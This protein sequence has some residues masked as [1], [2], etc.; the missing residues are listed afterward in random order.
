M[1]RRFSVREYHKMIEAGVF[2][3]GEPIELLEGYVVQKMARGTPYDFAVQALNKR[4]VRL[5]PSGWDVRVQ[6][7]I[8]LTESEPEPDFAIVRGDESA[9]RDH[10]PGPAEIGTLI[11][12]SSSS[13]ATD[14][15]DKARIYA[16]AGIPEY[17]VV[18]VIEKVV[19]VFTRPSGPAEA[20]AYEVK[21]EYPVGTA[22]PIV[23]AGQLV[24]SIAVADVMG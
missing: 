24:G 20:P 3:D 16:R 13:L 1:F 2:V 18:I 11:E 21:E 12:I 9:Y 6:C 15:G 23:L 8:T 17:W 4:L 10:H 7:A 14:R 22:I 19:E 5:L